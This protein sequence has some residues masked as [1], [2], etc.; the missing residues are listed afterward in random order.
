M[1]ESTVALFRADIIGRYLQFKA[2]VWC[3][4]G[5]AYEWG[6]YAAGVSGWRD[7]FRSFAFYLLLFG[8]PS[9][10]LWVLGMVTRLRH[11]LA[12]WF[13]VGYLLACLVGKTTFGTAGLP[14]AMWQ[15]TSDRLPPFYLRGFAAFTLFSTLILA[16]DI[17]ALISLL[18]PLGRE[19][20]GIG[21][22]EDGC[23]DEQADS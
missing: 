13:G 9:V 15:W 17:V 23:R 22:A 21:S 16:A 10:L 7:G 6:F 11:P 8:T 5:I 20:F 2:V 1:T 3:A 18:S 4:V 19:C 12:W 14:V